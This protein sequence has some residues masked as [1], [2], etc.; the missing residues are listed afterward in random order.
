MG[1]VVDHHDVID[2]AERFEPSD[3]LGD[4]LGFVVG[5]QDHCQSAAM[6]HSATR[7]RVIDDEAGDLESLIAIQWQP[8][9]GRVV[10]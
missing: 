1:V 5:G 6:P 7:P 10:I 8:Q 2:D 3:A 9:G 4:A